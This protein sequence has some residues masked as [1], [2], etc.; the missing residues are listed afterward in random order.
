MSEINIQVYRYRWTVLLLFMFVNI[1]LQILWISFAAVT[2]EAMAFYNVDEIFI[3]LLSMSFMI[4][5]IPITFLASWLIDKYDFKIGAGIGA[6]LAGTFGLLR[7]FAFTDYSLVLIFQIVIAIGQPFVLN[8]ITK[9]SSNWFPESERTTATGL[10]LISQFIGI[11]LGMIITPML[12][13]GDDLMLMLFIYGMIAL[14]SCILFLIFAKSKPPTPPSKEAISE[15]VLMSEGLRQLFTNK[16]FLILVILFFIGLGAFNM[17]SSYIELII[18]PKGYGAEEAGMLGGIMLLG[19]I[20]GAIIMSTLSDKYKKRKT[21]ILTSVL[22]AGISLFG[23]AFTSDLIL[24]YIFSSLLGFG[25]LSAGPVA[26]EY[27]VDITRPVPEASSNGILLMVGQMGGILFILGLVDFTYNGDYF[28]ALILLGF[29]IV[30]LF[31]LGFFLKETNK[32]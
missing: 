32:E 23:L 27:A 19:G 15:K 2:L 13:A 21:L 26:L 14:I 31:I 30:I 9:L 1:T 17:I 10:S 29:L 11:A 4:V 20:I 24:L 5:Y 12:V 3:L 6:T 25:I 7:F 16:H 8:S 28:P 22:I 18:D